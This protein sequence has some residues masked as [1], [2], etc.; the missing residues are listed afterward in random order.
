MIGKYLARESQ[1]A[2][3]GCSGP[4]RDGSAGPRSEFWLRDP[5]QPL[6]SLAPAASRGHCEAGV[7]EVFRPRP[8]A[9]LPL[10][11]GS[12]HSQRLFRGRPGDPLLTRFCTVR[13]AVY[14]PPAPLRAFHLHICPSACRSRNLVK[15]YSSPGHGIPFFWLV[16]KILLRTFYCHGHGNSPLLKT[17]L[18]GK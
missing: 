14:T 4:H 16:I 9:E 18:A 7:R 15:P 3:G 8:R 11:C 1:E 13:L 10:C 5:R 12:C 17:L 6:A 2:S